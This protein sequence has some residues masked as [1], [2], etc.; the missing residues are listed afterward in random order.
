MMLVQDFKMQMSNRYPA[1]FLDSLP[2]ICLDYRC[3]SP[4]EMSEVM[5][6][7]KCS[8]PRCPTKVANR[9]VAIANALGVKDLGVARANAFISKFGCLNP[10]MI[11][12]YEADADGA[13]GEGVSMDISKRVEEQFSHKKN[14]T[15]WEF[16][17]VA[18]LPYIQN[19]ALQIFGDYDDLEKAYQ[20]IEN[21]GVD[22]IRLKLHIA[23]GTSSV[24]FKSAVADGEALESE[25]VDISVRALKV[26]TSLMTFKYDLFQALPNV[27]IIKLNDSSVKTLKVVCSEEV[28][29]GFRTKADFYSTVNSLYDNLHVEFLSSV[30]RKIDYLVWAGADGDTSVRVTN[31]VEKVRKYNEGYEASKAAGTLKKGDHYIPILT[32]S[33]FLEEIKKFTN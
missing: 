31:K 29:A 7:L 8:N 9:M 6:G 12:A 14:F 21:G 26:Y 15:L 2:D 4:T 3:G 11:F 30:T 20:D 19:S 32:A 28:G 17:R 18:N 33:Q 25:V 22:F 24:L 16:V 10:M 5:T 27:N 1:E 13:L 23:K